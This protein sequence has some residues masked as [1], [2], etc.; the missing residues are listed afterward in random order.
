MIVKKLEVFNFFL[1]VLIVND[2]Y[3]FVGWLLIFFYIKLKMYCIFFIYVYFKLKFDVVICRF[4]FLNMFVNL[5]IKED[6][7]KGI[8]GI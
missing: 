2:I 1:I 8:F 6:Y 3:I 4:Y 5:I 7:N